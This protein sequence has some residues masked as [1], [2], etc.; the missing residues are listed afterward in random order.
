M[1]QYNRQM[2]ASHT[3][4]PQRST[5]FWCTLVLALLA[6]AIHLYIIHRYSNSMPYRDDFEAIFGFLNPLPDFTATQKFLHLFSQNNEH[7][8]F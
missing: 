2:Q 1:Q 3:K 6:T 4:H 7:R 5:Y 8:I